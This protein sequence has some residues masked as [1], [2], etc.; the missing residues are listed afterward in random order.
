MRSAKQNIIGRGT[1]FNLARK[2]YVVKADGSRAPFDINKVKATCIRAGASNATATRIARSVL[3]QCYDGISTKEIYRQVLAALAFE[4][5]Q[6]GLQHRYRLKESL[7]LMG[8]AGFAFE[9]YLGQ[10]LERHDYAVEAI[11]S[12]VKGRCVEHEIDIVAVNKSNEK[13]MVECKYHNAPGIRTGLKES[14]YT[15]ARFLDLNEA[16]RTF[17]R[18]MLVTNTNVTDEVLQ[19]SACVGQLTLSWRHPQDRGLEKMIEEKGLYP[20]TM[21]RLTKSELAAF[22]QASFMIAKDLLDVQLDQFSIQTGIPLARLTGLQ[23]QVRQILR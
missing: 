14:L 5:D 7:M 19:Y 10:V 8:P 2:T 9:A 11:G 17:D 21:L 23:E 1:Q 12:K 18:E 3:E 16:S 20:V 4:T 22:S 13:Y 6:P 15:H